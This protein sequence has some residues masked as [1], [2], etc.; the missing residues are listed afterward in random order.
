MREER[1]AQQPELRS[2]GHDAWIAAVGTRKSLDGNRHVYEGGQGHR[3]AVVES[4]IRQGSG[5][6]REGRQGVEWREAD[7]IGEKQRLPFVLY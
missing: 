3:T 6:L 7:R 4:V 1:D 2:Q 5:P